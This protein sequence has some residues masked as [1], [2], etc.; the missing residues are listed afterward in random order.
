MTDST[1]NITGPLTIGGTSTNQPITSTQTVTAPPFSNPHHGFGLNN[2]IGN[3][4]ATDHAVNTL[5]VL[6]NFGTASYGGYSEGVHIENNLTSATATSTP[7][8][9]RSYTGITVSAAAQSEDNGVAGTPRGMFYGVFAG[10]GN[11]DAA[12]TGAGATYPRTLVGVRGNVSVYASTNPYIRVGVEAADYGSGSGGQGTQYDAA[13]S[14]TAL[15]GSA[16]WKNGILF[17]PTAD[18]GFNYNYSPMSSTGTLIAADSHNSFAVNAGIDWGT[19]TFTGN[20]YN[21]ANFSINGST[22][23]VAVKLG[24]LSVGALNPPAGTQRSVQINGAATGTAPGS[25]VFGYCGPN[26]VWGIGNYSSMFGGSFDGTCLIYS[27]LS[28]PSYRFFG[29][30]AGILTSSSNGTV[31]V[32]LSPTLRPGASVT[33]ANN[34]DLVIEATSNMTLTFKFKGSD[35]VVRSGAIALT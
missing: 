8:A 24:S 21:S 33:P 30:T 11:F 35:G 7:D 15:A 31:S 3:V 20:E 32:A 26:P 13:I 23:N 10:A 6:Q 12:G 1:L 18:L 16:G 25:F 19:W 4:Y 34:G 22:G 2:F 27:G 14:V 9:N 28:T 5:T 29:L 17:A